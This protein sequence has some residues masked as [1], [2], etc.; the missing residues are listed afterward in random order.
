M[1]GPQEQRGPQCVKCLSRW[2]AGYRSCRTWD[3]KPCRDFVLSVSVGGHTVILPSILSPQPADLQGRVGQQPNPPYAGS[4]GTTRSVP[5]Q[6]VAHR[7]FHLAGQHSHASHRGSNI[8][9]RLEDGRRIC[10]SGNTTKT[11]NKQS[12]N[13]LL[14]QKDVCTGMLCIM[15]M[16]KPYV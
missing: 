6:V 4:D 3:M 8:Y 12:K 7:S 1:T 14:F 15:L 11:S 9:C 5:G 10:F 16:F 13:S 2:P